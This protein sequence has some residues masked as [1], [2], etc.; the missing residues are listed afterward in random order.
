MKRLKVQQNYLVLIMLILGIFL[1]AGCSSSSDNGTGAGS[2]VPGAC[3]A[4]GPKLTVSNPTSGNLSVSTS[5]ADGGVAGKVITATFSAAM[6][7][8]TIDSATPGAMLTF[9]IKETVSGTNVPGT[10]AMNTPFNTIATFRTSAPLSVNTQYSATITTAAQSAVGIALGCS[11]SWKFT[12][13]AAGG[14]SP[15]A[16]QAPVDLGTAST[17]GVFASHDAAVTLT[18]PSV[19]V[20]GDV[21]LMDGAG[22]CTGCLEGT[23]VTGVINNGNLAAAQAQ[24]DLNAAYIDASTRLTNACTVNTTNLAVAQGACTGYLNP[25]GSIGPTTHNTYLP[26]LYVSGSTIQIASGGIIVLDAQGDAD[27]VF[28]FQAGSAITTGDNSQVLLAGNAQAKN[29]FW[30]ANSAVNLGVSTLFKGTAIANT[31]AITVLNGT[32]GSPTLVVGRLFSHG[33]A[34]SM[35]TFDTVTVPAP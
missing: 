15:A 25:P 28:I 9:T 19:L 33:A 4:A 14:E 26:G 20:D 35:D 31:G 10:V 24:I 32:S 30:V 1:I 16:G 6:D 12:T 8:T 18:G 11:Y 7:P 5:T 3:T 2:V 21:G 17:Y 23:T 34:I 13:V 22:V 27:A 29:V